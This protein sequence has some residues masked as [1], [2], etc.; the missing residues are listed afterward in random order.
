MVSVCIPVFNFDARQLVKELHIEL[1][2]LQIEGEILVT[3][4]CSDIHFKKLNNEVQNLEFVKY[5]ELEKNIGRSAIRNSLAEKAQY[6]YLIFLDC[7]M[8]L[9]NEDFLKKY[10]EKI[11]PD[12]VLVG[13]LSYQKERPKDEFILHWK[14]GK[15]REVKSVEQRSINPY[16]SFLSSNFLVPKSVFNEIKFDESLRQYGHEDT[17]FG[18]ELK[19]LGVSILHIEN[20]IEHT[21]LETANTFLFKTEKAIENLALL[22]SEKK[23]EP[24]KLIDTYLKINRLGIG[25]LVFPLLKLVELFIVKN[26]ESTSPSL[27]FFDLFKLLKFRQ[28]RTR[29]K[30]S[31]TS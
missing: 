17:L 24:T 15:E 27:S 26:V 28:N 8:K 23:I 31:K 25:W 22:Y 4:D 7:D 6:E 13:G 16:Q 18:L 20:P 2:K 29:L 3:D 21:G 12:T 30:E 11:S 9:N 14:V 19:R 10:L 1:E 5:E